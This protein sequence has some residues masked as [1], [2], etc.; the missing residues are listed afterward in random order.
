MEN[1]Y[2][3]RKDCNY[4]SQIV[5]QVLQQNKK[6]LDIIKVTQFSS[7]LMDTSVKIVFLLPS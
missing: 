1:E 4:L 2:W 3:T 5:L 7:F 6:L